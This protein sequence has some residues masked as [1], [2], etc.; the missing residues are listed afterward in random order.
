M[1]ST[2][3]GRQIEKAKLILSE[4]DKIFAGIDCKDKGLA[5]SILASSILI[6]AAIDSLADSGDLI[7]NMIKDKK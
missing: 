2:Q 4:I 6:S 1:L 5:M 3:V 7:A